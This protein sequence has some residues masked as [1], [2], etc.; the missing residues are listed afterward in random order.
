MRPIPAFVWAFL[1]AAEGDERTGYADSGGRPTIG[2]GHTDPTVR[3]GET[4]SQAEDDELFLEDQQKA[5]FVVCRELGDAVD[6]LSDHQYGALISFVFNVGSLGPTIPRLVAGGL[7]SA[8]PAVIFKYNHATVG[9]KLVEV[10]GLTRRRTAEV[11]LWKMGDVSSATVLGQAKAEGSPP[12]GEAMTDLSSLPTTGAP[13][14][15]FVIAPASFPTSKPAMSSMTVAGGLIAICSSMTQI[16]PPLLAAAGFN[17]VQATAVINGVTAIGAVVGGIMA[18]I[19]R[20]RARTTL[21]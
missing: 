20:F 15:P 10:L 1:D 18:I 7:L 4:I 8:V 17:G 19:G 13:T 6:K 21:H 12:T 2:R 14:P 9:G 11:V 5:A 16:L 3:I